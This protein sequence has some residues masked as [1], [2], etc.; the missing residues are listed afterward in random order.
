M[1]K[2]DDKRKAGFTLI[3]LIAVLTIMLVVSTSSILSYSKI[4]HQEEDDD[5]NKI[6]YSINSAA[7]TY[8][9]VSNLG[10]ASYNITLD[11]LRANGLIVSNLVNPKTNNSIDYL[12]SYV[13]VETETV[14]SS[15]KCTYN[16][17]L[18]DVN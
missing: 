13:S 8:L 7:K 5:Y 12:N 17:T 2:N 6:V 18:N 4:L 15:K 14:D 9:S 11:K 16:V 1:I 10:C 3:E